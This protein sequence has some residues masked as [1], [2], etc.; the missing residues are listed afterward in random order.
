M[1]VAANGSWSVTFSKTQLPPGEYELPVKVTSTDIHGNVTVVHDTLVVDTF[2]NVS[3]GENQAGDNVI[4]GAEADGGVTLTG[5][6]QAGSSVVV[7]FQSLSHTVIA[8]ANG[9]WSTNFGASEIRDGT[10]ASTVTVTATDAAGNTATDSHSVHVDTEVVPLTRATISAG[11]GGVVNALEAALGLTVTGTVEPGSTVMV[12]FANGSMQGATVD[13]Q[14]RWTVII[15]AGEIPVGEN[16][17]TMTAYATDQYGNTTNITE[18]VAVDTLVRNL[19]FTGGSIC[20]DGV[21]NAAEAADGL[22]L[23]GRIEPNS[24]LVARRSNGETITTTANAAGNWSVTFAPGRLP[25]GE[26]TD[27]NVTVTATDKAGNTDTIVKHFDYDTTAPGAPQVVSFTRDARGAAL[28]RYGDDRR[29]LLLHPDRCERKSDHGFDAGDGGCRRR[30]ELVQVR[31]DGAGRQ[32]SGDQH[33]RCC[34]QQKLDL[35]DRGLY[36]GTNG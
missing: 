2:T 36:L 3:I 12:K 4:S 16:L 22:T 13:A 29:Y 1:T 21:L 10:Y 19:A 24:T 5:M 17:V 8:G 9:T 31:T 15:P 18:Q 30:R 27:A 20:G 34:R 6:A 25:Q 26:G 14:G 7:T 32:L 35:A 11:S 33:D 23:T 28:D